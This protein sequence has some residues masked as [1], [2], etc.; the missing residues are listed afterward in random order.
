M[1]T[2]IAEIKLTDFL[3]FDYRYYIECYMY[4]YN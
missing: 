2:V 1:H 3:L 4:G